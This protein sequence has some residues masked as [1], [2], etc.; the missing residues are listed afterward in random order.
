[1]F[2]ERA[3]DTIGDVELD[4]LEVVGV[5]EIDLGQGDDAV[6]LAEQ[7]EDAQVLLRLR[8]PTLGGRDDEE[9]RVHRP[10]AR[11]HVLDE[12]HVT[13]DVDEGDAS[14]RTEVQSTQSRGRS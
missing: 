9:A 2:E 14:A 3:R 6:L 13:G 5:D 11:E 1:M 4:E 7:L 8:L 12:A 10:D